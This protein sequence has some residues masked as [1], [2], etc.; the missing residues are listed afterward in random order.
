MGDFK[1]DYKAIGKWLEADPALHAYLDSV[2]KKA[3]EYA[4]SIAPV[5]DKTSKYTHP[6]A[7]RDGI[8]GYVAISKGRMR[9]RVA[10]TDWKS[11]F[12]EYGTKKM[13]KDAVLRR[14]LDH[15]R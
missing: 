5:G 15:F 6:G 14:T 13:P 2:A 7:Y 1:I 4:R 12:I 11:H 10:A 3:A 8:I 9:A